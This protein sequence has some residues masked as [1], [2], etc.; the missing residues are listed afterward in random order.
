M[1]G[2]PILSFNQNSKSRVAADSVVYRTF[3]S[4]GF[5]AISFLD[6]FFNFSKQLCSSSHCMLVVH[7]N[8]FISYKLLCDP[9]FLPLIYNVKSF[10]FD[11]LSSKSWHNLDFKMLWLSFKS[12][13]IIN[14]HIFI[15]IQKKNH[16][17][18]SFHIESSF[19]PSL[20]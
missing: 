16:T 12:N 3:Q 20:Y 11:M 17:R 4:I 18:I 5:G 15:N 9:I 8:G 13:W 6:S 10:L 7:S 2:L 19:F 1:W 14:I